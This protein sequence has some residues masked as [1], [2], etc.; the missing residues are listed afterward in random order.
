MT[1]WLDVVTRPSLN[2][3]PGAQRADEDV[4]RGG[5]GQ[6]PGRA[7]RPLRHHLSRAVRRADFEF[8][9]QNARAGFEF[10]AEKLGV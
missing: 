9:A 5:A 8:R 2:T 6:V 7:A 4:P 10:R 3:I 1:D